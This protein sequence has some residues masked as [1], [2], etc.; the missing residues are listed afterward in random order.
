MHFLWVQGRQ[1]MGSWMTVT[2]FFRQGPL[3]PVQGKC[4]PNQRTG[5]AMRERRSHGRRGRI[6]RLRHA[7]LLPV[8]GDILLGCTAEA[9]AERVP[10]IGC[11][12]GNLAI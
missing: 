5:P 12:G 4:D 10:H 7:R 11:D 2:S 9:V 3:V 6:P 1:A 8:F